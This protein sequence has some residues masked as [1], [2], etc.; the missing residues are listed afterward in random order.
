[1]HRPLF[2][3]EV[4]TKSPYGYYGKLY[5]IELYHQA[6]RYADVVSVHTHSDWGGSF[7]QLKWCCK[8]TEKPILAKGIHATDSEII[9]ALD[10]GA[11]SVLVVGRLPEKSLRQHCLIEPTSLEELAS[12]PKGE[13][14]N[15]VWNARDLKDGTPKT[16]TWE[17]ARKIWSGHLYQASL[18]KE[19][20]DVQPNCDGFIVG[21]NLYDFAEKWEIDKFRKL[22]NI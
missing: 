22:H 10:F 17:Q 21:E 18:I 8:N 3:G 9:Q 19:L 20:K 4:K 6:Q 1:M 7:K 13:A 12:Y 2:I 11:S 14:L 15:V 5:W 16:E